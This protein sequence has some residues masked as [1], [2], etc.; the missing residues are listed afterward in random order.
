MSTAKSPDWASIRER[1]KR[2]P[3]AAFQFVRE[4]LHQAVRAVHGEHGRGSAEGGGRSRHITGQQLSMALRSYAIE[5]YGPLALTVL[6]RWGVRRTED[7]GVLVY[8]M[9][10][11]GEMRASPQDSLEDFR[12]VYD[13][14]EALAPEAVRG[15][16]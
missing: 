14:D 7:F 6:R 5:L 1:A 8:A 13:L 10:E 4:G 15:E 16:F 12:D 11:R 3:P 2:F 9:I